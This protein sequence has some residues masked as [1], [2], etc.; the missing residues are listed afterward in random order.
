[1]AFAR[2]KRPSKPNKSKIVSL[3]LTETEHADFD[4]LKN[5]LQFR[6]MRE[7]ILFSLDVIEELDK[8]SCGGHRFYISNTD[9]GEYKEI[10]FELR[11]F[12][13]PERR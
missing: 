7:L 6:S 12:I 1:M 11:P 4:R 13:E 3:R 2:V 10:E 8:W 9:T 5:D